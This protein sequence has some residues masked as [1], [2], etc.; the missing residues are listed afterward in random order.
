MNRD[1]VLWLTFGFTFSLASVI[2]VGILLCWHVYLVFTNQVHILVFTLCILIIIYMKTTI[3]FYMNFD[4]ATEA[5]S[6]G[7]SF[8]NPFDRGWRK[9]LKR[10]IGDKNILFL[11][12]PVKVEPSGPEYPFELPG[13]NELLYV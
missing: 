8:R 10:I 1:V 4:A 11:L 5:K 2:S 7:Q 6:R 13:S 9:N 12:L 3:E